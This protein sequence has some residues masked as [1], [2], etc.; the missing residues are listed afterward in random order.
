MSKHDAIF[1]AGRRTPK[2]VKRGEK[3]DPKPSEG[4]IESR[5]HLT[6]E[7]EKVIAR[8]D[9]LRVNERGETPGDPGYLSK[10]SKVR[11]QLNSAGGFD[12]SEFGLGGWLIPLWGPD[13]DVVSLVSPDESLVAAGGLD[14]NRGN[15]ERLRRYWTKGP[16]AAKIRWGTAGDWERCVA[17]LSEY[18]GPRAQGYCSLR[19]KEVTGEWTGDMSHR[20]KFGWGGKPGSYWAK[21]AANS[22]EDLLSTTA[23]DGPF[24]TFHFY[25][26]IDSEPGVPMS[27]SGSNSPIAAGGNPEGGIVDIADLFKVEPAKEVAFRIPMLLPEGIPSGDGRT[28]QEGVLEVRDL[29]L[30]LLWQPN[31]Q[32]GHDGSVVVGR[33]DTLKRVA[34]GLGEATGVFD[35]SPIAQEAVRLIR[36]G[37]LRG[38]SADLD[39]FEAKVKAKKGESAKGDG[40]GEGANEAAKKDAEEVIKPD[41]MTITKGRV[42]A[43]TIVAKPAFQ[44]ASILIDEEPEP[45]PDGDHVLAPP[46]GSDLVRDY[47]QVRQAAVLEAKWVAPLVASAGVS[48]TIPDAPPLG[49]FED[50][51]LSKPTHLTITDD[52]RVFG[53]IA[54]WNVDHIGMPFGTRPPRSRSNYSYFRTGLLRTVEGEDVRVG[55]LTLTGG[56]APLGADARQAVRHYDDTASAFADVAAGEDQWGIWV[57]GALRPGVT[58]AQIRVARASSPSGDWRPI[59]NSLE[60]VAV[61]QVNVPGFPVVQARVA[62]GQMRALVAAGVSPLVAQRLYIDPLSTGGEGRDGAVLSAR[63]RFSRARMGLSPEGGLVAGGSMSMTMG[64]DVPSTFQL[65]GFEQSSALSL[66]AALRAVRQSAQP[67]DETQVSRDN[68]G[69]FRTI[70]YR[71]KTSPD[72]EKPRVR[73]ALRA[74]RRATETGATEDAVTAQGALKEAV[75]PMKDPTQQADIIE[76]A[77]SM[78]RLIER[79]SARGDAS[80]M[81]FDQL[82]TEIQNAISRYLRQSGLEGRVERHFGPFMRGEAHRSVGDIVNF[83]ERIIVDGQKYHKGYD[84]ARI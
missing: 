43:A 45:L 8:G 55:Q 83:I 31:S 19:H 60:L 82:P 81:S 35:T 80:K 64:S 50:P 56:H 54:A 33:I 22:N 77:D 49:W 17:H 72:S 14:R 18:L 46:E 25:K 65:T 69:R 61:C 79:I 6:D 29:P 36:N 28:F 68:I 1:L 27:I 78:S 39:K 63:A 67:W 23:G 24:K 84:T 38:V 44:E 37:F 13:G 16:G 62:S 42:M 9:W 34:G 52:G 3:Y 53:H 76:A 51:G 2:I 59:G 26:E 21:V 32:Q 30:P 58:A 11:P 66:V 75:D 57:A 47:E 48:P 5:R 41:E 71:L 10:K 12:G 20:I 7:E 74:L 40:V 15:A 70:Y 4:K 73:A